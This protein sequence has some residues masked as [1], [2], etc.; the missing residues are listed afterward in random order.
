MR[1]MYSAERRKCSMIPVSSDSIPAGGIGV[2]LWMLVATYLSPL[3]SPINPEKSGIS[4]MKTRLFFGRPT[5]S[6]C[7]CSTMPPRDRERP[8]MPISAKRMMKVSA[9]SWKSTTF[10][11]PIPAARRKRLKVRI[12]RS[13]PVRLSQM[14]PALSPSRVS[15]V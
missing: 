2:P 12:E 4:R 6:I 5:A 3:E 9:R 8:S 7:N 10:W 14:S 13:T 1:W 15:R 11:K